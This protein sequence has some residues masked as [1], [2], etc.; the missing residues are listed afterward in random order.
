MAQDTSLGGGGEVAQECQNI[1]RGAAAPL[2]PAPM[3]SPLE[4]SSSY[5]RL[6]NVAMVKVEYSILRSCHRKTDAI[7]GHG[8]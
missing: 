7:L 4:V 3:P 6:S 8:T 1:S 2:L 5:S